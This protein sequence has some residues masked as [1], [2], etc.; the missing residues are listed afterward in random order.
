MATSERDPL[1]HAII[2]C[3]IAVHREMGPGLLESAYD[4]CLARELGKSGMP[5]VRQPVTRISYQGTLL[6]RTYRPDFV[7]NAEVVVEVKSVSNILP[8]HVAQTLTYMRLSRIERGL[9]LNFNV[10][11]MIQGIRRLI[12]SR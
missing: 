6:D 2:A 3:A 12:L 5:L 8:V 4:V 10:P 7:V 9:I 1:T 11:L